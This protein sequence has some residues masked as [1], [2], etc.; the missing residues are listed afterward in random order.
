MKKD[1]YSKRLDKQKKD[2]HKKPKI[3][4]MSVEVEYKKYD[5]EGNEN[6]DLDVVCFC[7][8]C[9]GS[10][11]IEELK[12]TCE[13]EKHESISGEYLCP[14]CNSDKWNYD[15]ATKEAGYTCTKDATIS[16][17]QEP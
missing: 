8:E 1:A 12:V 4:K 6:N 9:K 13:L 17:F 5:K 14:L 3:T 7:K 15:K 16:Y 10:F 2:Y 11:K